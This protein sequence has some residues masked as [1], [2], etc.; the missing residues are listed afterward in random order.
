LYLAGKIN[1]STAEQLRNNLVSSMK[2]L[3]IFQLSWH[4]NGDLLRNFLHDCIPFSCATVIAP[5]L[6]SL[7]K[8][9]ETARKLWLWQADFRE[10]MP[11]GLLE[12]ASGFQG[13]H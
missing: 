13:Q 11:L 12:Y 4:N 1:D 7:Q 8:S 9:C 5:Y 6:L 2:K 10:N 3:Y